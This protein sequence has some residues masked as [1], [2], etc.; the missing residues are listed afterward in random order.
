M[1][2][3]VFGYRGSSVA[4]MR[5]LGL[6]VLLSVANSA[7]TADLQ[8]L[9]P[10]TRIAVP[11][12]WTESLATDRHTRVWRCPDSEVGQASI[13]ALVQTADDQRDARAHLD[14]ALGLLSRLAT[15]F[16]IVDPIGPSIE[17]GEDWM[18]ASYRFRTGDQ[19][20]QQKVIM[21]RDKQR[22]ITLTCSAIREAYDQW[23]PTFTA[24]CAPLVH[25]PSRIGQ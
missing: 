13:A 23:T 17:L 21:R 24:V 4:M 10:T 7:W 2:T 11:A 12:T 9:T 14:E 22:M 20:W 15:D 1:M 19:V 5:C 18:Q 6:F 16:T 25:R 3:A 8:Q